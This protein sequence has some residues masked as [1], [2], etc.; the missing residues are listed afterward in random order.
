MIPTYLVGLEKALSSYIRIG[1]VA[2]LSF[3]WVCAYFFARNQ[4]LPNARIAFSP[5]FWHV[6]LNWFYWIGAIWIVSAIGAT[7]VWVYLM[8]AHGE[9]S[10]S[11]EALW[12]RPVFTR[13]A[14][15]ALPITFTAV[16][17]FECW[18]WINR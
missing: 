7:I 16:I 6:V 14:L 4:L 13:F 1:A 2:L 3:A 15:K 17:L 10:R 18:N 12:S 5:S 11:V 8:R 9:D